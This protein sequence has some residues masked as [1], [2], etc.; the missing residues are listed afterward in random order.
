M[1]R[2]SWWIAALLFASTLLNY[3]DRQILSL[4]SPILR[5]QFSLTARQYSH[6]FNAFLL[7]YTS[8]Q[9]L[10]GWIVDRLGAKRGLMLA[11]LWWSAAGAAAAFAKGP[12][13]LAIC[14]F[15]MGLG[16]AANWPSAV[17]AIGEWFPAGKR[18]AA[19]GFFNAGSSA[20]AVLAPIVVSALTQRYSWR[21]AFLTCGVL[22]LLWVGPW[23]LLYRDPPVQCES[24]TSVQPRFSYLADRRAW[25]VILA[26]FFADSIWFFYIFWLPDYL[27][28]VQSVNLST[29][30][31]IAW[32]PFLAAGVGNFAGGAASGY[33]IRR[34]KLAVPARLTVMGASA[35]VMSGGITI[36]YCHSPF[37]AIALISVI[38]FAY[39]SWAAN[40]LTLPSD[41]FPPA[42]VG[43]I[44]GACGTVAGLGGILTTLLT[45]QIIDRYSYGPVFVGLSCLPLLAFGFSLLA[46]TGSPFGLARTA[47]TTRTWFT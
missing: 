40:V 32:I 5:V 7:G 8:M 13:Q 44:T 29:L 12:Q 36:R 10:A 25:G 46:S 16:E 9:F 24:R 1:I 14:L 19:V 18:A 4:L 34:H 17:K 21:A 27:T 26:R 30:G 11:M 41:L 39:S 6:L 2:R 47:G 28:R 42:V 31:A 3:F 37:Q 43:T 45:G 22:A 35:L 33:L 20:G 23:Q 38:V 15:L